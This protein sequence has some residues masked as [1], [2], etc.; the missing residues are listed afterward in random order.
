MDEGRK[1]GA[2]K[3]RY[4]KSLLT[5]VRLDTNNGIYSLA[6]AIVETENTQSWKWFL[7]CL[8]DDLDL[9]ANSNFT[10]I[11]DKQKLF[12]HVLSTCFVLE[13]LQIQGIQR[14]LMEVCHTNNSPRVQH[15]MRKFNCFEKQAYDWLKKIPPRH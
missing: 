13:N 4:V 8:G 3:E 7:E 12:P 15:L 11:S 5:I 1:Q 14:A 2:L 9:Y 10:F 6:Y